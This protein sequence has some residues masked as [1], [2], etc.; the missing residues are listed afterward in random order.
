MT[1]KYELETKRLILISERVYCGY[2]WMLVHWICLCFSLFLFT[3][4]LT[5]L[6]IASSFKIEESLHKMAISLKNGRIEQNNHSYLFIWHGLP[7]SGDHSLRLLDILSVHRLCIPFSL[8]QS[9]TRLQK[10]FSPNADALSLWQPPP[11]YI[12]G[13]MRVPRNLDSLFYNCPVL[14]HFLSDFFFSRWGWEWVH[15]SSLE[16][17]LRTTIVSDGSWA[18]HHQASLDCRGEDRSNA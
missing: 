2:P 12:Y 6:V 11:Q 1:I 13:R 15:I 14:D 5:L 4:T 8:P 3:R 18:I 7:F 16:S 9:K 10:T 17:I